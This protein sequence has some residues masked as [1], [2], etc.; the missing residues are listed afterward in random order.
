MRGHLER[1]E[2]EQ[3]EATRRAVRAVQLVDAKFSAM[4]VAG[5]VDQQIAEQ[6]IDEPWRSLP[7]GPTVGVELP[8]REIELVNAVV[9]GLVDAGRLA[10]W[11]DEHPGE[12]IRERRVIEPIP[13]EAPVTRARRRLMR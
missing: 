2:L 8:E 4:R 11:A 13:D 1:A 9:S 5:D 10:R 7:P 3:S 6:T 12:E